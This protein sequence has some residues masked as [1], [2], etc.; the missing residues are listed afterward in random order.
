MSKFYLNKAKYKE[1]LA[2]IAI[3][4]IINIFNSKYLI[5]FMRIEI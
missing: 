3:Q 5:D 2:D 4:G 1:S